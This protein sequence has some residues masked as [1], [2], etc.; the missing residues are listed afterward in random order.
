[1]CRMM[2]LMEESSPNLRIWVLTLSA[3]RMT[4]SMSMTPILEPLKPSIEAEVSPLTLL[5][6]DQTS[7][8]KSRAMTAREPPRMATQNHAE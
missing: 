8:V 2:A 5:T 4:P 1:M 3:S 7:A 6:M